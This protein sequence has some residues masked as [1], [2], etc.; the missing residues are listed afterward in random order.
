MG[1]IH[2]DEGLYD[3]I[4]K[5]YDDT[6]I[7]IKDFNKMHHEEELGKNNKKSIEGHDEDHDDRKEKR[8]VYINE[9]ANQTKHFINKI[10]HYCENDNS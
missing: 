8:K 7:E 3:N 2:I 1:K 5:S 9:D 4:K 10:V 6:K